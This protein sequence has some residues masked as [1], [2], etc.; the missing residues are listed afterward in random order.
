MPR[1]ARAGERR[2]RGEA[3]RIAA[4]R[5][6]PRSAP[7]RGHR[8][9]GTSPSPRARGEIMFG[10]LDRERVRARD[11]GWTDLVT[12]ALPTSLRWTS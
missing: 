9:C 10:A 12:P 8:Q 3:L 11:R 7:H 5:G 2:E 4:N 6:A 1:A